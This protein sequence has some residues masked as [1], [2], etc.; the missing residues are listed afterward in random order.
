VVEVSPAKGQL[1]RESFTIKFNDALAPL[2]DPQG[3]PI[4]PVTVDP[5]LPGKA[6]IE[7]NAITFTVDQKSQPRPGVYAVHLNPALRSASGGALPPDQAPLFFATT[8]LDVASLEVEDLDAAA[9]R[10]RLN[11]SVFVKTED[12]EASLLVTDRNG[13]AVSRTIEG[14]SPTYSLALGIPRTAELPVTITLKA[15][16]RDATGILENTQD[17]TFTYPAAQPLTVKVDKWR[18]AQDV[19]NRLRLDFSAPVQRTLLQKLLRVARDDN[20]EPLSF[21]VDP[22]GEVSQAFIELQGD[23]SELG[24]I[25]ITLP[26]GMPGKGLAALPETFTATV[27]RRSE[28]LRME[29]HWWN[30]RN[31]DGAVLN[32]ELNVRVKT[33]DFQKHLT[34]EPAI[35]NLKVEPSYGNRMLIS[36]DWLSE[37]VHRL[38]LSEGLM[39]TAGGVCVTTPTT[40]TLEETPKI[41]GTGFGQ[42]GKLYIPRRGLGQMTVEA[43]NLTE[44][45]LSVWQVFPVNLVPALDQV[46]GGMTGSGFNDRMAREVGTQTIQFPPA[47]NKKVSMPIN[48]TDLL[49]ADRRGVFT[50][51]FEE[52]ENWRNTRMILWTDIGVLAHW[53]NDE[54]AVFTHD[55]L[56]LAPL[57][58]A[59]VTVYSQKNQAMG[60]ATTDEQ[61]L[62]LIK[63]MDKSLGRPRMVVVETVNDCTFLAL[64]AREDDPTAFEAEMPGYERTGYDAFLYAD[65]NLYRPGETVH[66]RWL[67]RTNYGD[68]LAGV[69]LEMRLI[70]P[71]NQTVL[72]Q[73]VTLSSLGT[74][75]QDLTTEKTWL[76]GKYTLEM[77]V[78][79]A[80]TSI[81][82]ATFNLEE[83]VP[84]RIEAEAAIDQTRWVPNTPYAVSVTARHLFG[85]PASNRKCETKVI[86]RRGEFKSDAWREFRFKNDSEYTPEVISLG[87]AQTD[88]EGKAA[89]SYTYTP[90]PKVT[91][92]VDVT[93]R[94]EVFE[95]GGRSV[96][97]IT[98]ALLF[99]SDV[100]LGITAAS[101]EDNTV[102]VFAAAVRPDETPADLPA[103]KITLEKENWSYYVR[104]YSGYNEPKWT[105]RFEEVETRDVPLSAGRGS[106]KF[107][108][109]DYYGYYRVRVHSD[110]T[111]QFSTLAFYKNW[112]GVELSDTA[113]PSLI[114]ITLDKPEYNV[115]DEVT[116][117]VESPFDG[118]GMVVVQ[119]EEIYK[120]VPVDVKNGVAEARFGLLREYYPNVWVE[121]TVVHEVKPDRIGVYPFSSFAMANVPMLDLQRRVDIAY[122]GLPQEI[123]P[124]QEIQLPVLTK[125]AAGQ[126]VAAEITLAA[127]DEGIHD[128]LEYQDPDPYTWFQRSRKPDYRRAHYYDQVA[129]D[130]EGQPIGGDMIA[131]RLGKGN[132]RIDDNWVKPVALWSGAVQTDAQG[133]ATVA[134]HLPE[135]NGQLRLVAVAA[136]ATATGAHSEKLFVRRPYILRTTMPRFV[137]PGDQFK[138]GAV[139]MNTT[140]AACTARLHWTVTGALQAGE[141]SQ[142]MALAPHGEVSAVAEFA[143]GALPGQGAIQWDLE[144]LA[145]DGQSLEK[146]CEDAPIPVRPPAVYQQDHQ[147]AVVEPGQS[148]TFKNL[149]FIEDDGLENVL[150]VGANPVIR[151]KDALKWII[152]YPYGCVEQTTSRC[153]PMYALRKG[154]LTLEMSD[155]DSGRIQEY[156][157]AGIDRL[158]SMQMPSGGMSGWPWG[159]KGY[160]YGSVYACHFLTLVHRD[161]ELPLPEEDFKRLQ[162]YLRQLAKDWNDDSLSGRHLRAYALYVLA[163]DGDLDA[164]EQI[165]R[166]D[167]VPLPRASRYLLAA[168]LALNTQDPARVQTYLDTAPVEE[169]SARETHGTLNSEIRNTALEVMA[170]SHMNAPQEKLRE[171]IT[172]L[173][174]YLENQ[175]QYHPTYTTQEVAFVA[176]ALGMYLS[177]IQE[178]LDQV[179]GTITAAD[180]ETAIKGTETFSATEKGIRS[181][182]VTNTG[183]GPLFVDFT[184]AGIPAQPDLVAI[185]KGLS[186]AR[187]FRTDQG[188]SLDGA[189]F[190]QGGTY[191]IHLSLKTIA[192]LKNIIVADLLPAGFEIEN[193]RLDADVLAGQ[194]LAGALTPAYLEIRDDRLVAAFDEVPAGTQHF[195]YLVRA[196]A[197]GTFQYPAVHAEC[198]YDPEVR[199]AS[200]PGSAKVE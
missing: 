111:P 90:S 43:R 128:I 142:E 4:E 41:K 199:A 116:V 151:L 14:I 141:G 84:N 178:N 78:P 83:F 60:E 31:V 140:D 79:G 53:V 6:K 118:R 45:K 109:T 63:H 51:Q 136:S 67:V 98:N 64:E 152:K 193:P 122:P 198:M 96:T 95:L 149:K 124:G 46:E 134:F 114:K 26:A 25:R 12:L 69:P 19:S 121:A 150:L 81:G 42:T 108:F 197:P 106:T 189:A 173:V 166:F 126:P 154:A 130:F 157:R 22:E 97:G 139:I 49:P 186:V 77:R 176:T 132:P 91:F 181:Y 18:T 183:N 168:A 129:Y 103:V 3:N 119:G 164:L 17:R 48:V 27:R 182:T 160:D 57:V 8:P 70:S 7:A 192:P 71:K 30:D 10:F 172:P 21:L 52:D 89:F 191:L 24:A 185:E 39:D 40:I 184:T 143:A 188:A 13:A 74:G 190:E 28:A 29:Y 88:S 44:A 23:I 200:L 32:L 156:L 133:Q 138:C 55:L 131:R 102:E 87:E 20:G 62:A 1:L 167:S 37:T 73:A 158:F 72:T 196:V 110:A 99:P 35:E 125:D 146:F 115:G 117:R 127:V 113:R 47:P 59:K 112:R 177:N 5:P 85:T 68:A 194:N 174:Q 159:S 82:T 162:E 137:L 66:A 94:G 148:R 80:K 61:G 75:G 36:G 195:Y 56:T 2:Q 58:Q 147:F 175:P 155:M 163:L 92:P 145:P 120:I 144:V 65:R 33:E 187:T 104:R 86:L 171:K 15:G 38:R 169:F 135:F 107:T 100:A 11:F 180:K 50:L 34:V 101:G 76:T 105:R 16:F 161:R 123:R 9:V 179:S 165:R 54:L 153:L 170:L 93:V